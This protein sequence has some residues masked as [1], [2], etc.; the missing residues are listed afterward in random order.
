MVW[1]SQ[2]ERRMSL[3][4]SGRPLRMPVAR[5]RS[6]SPA[7]QLLDRSD[8]TRRSQH[9]DARETLQFRR[10]SV[11]SAWQERMAV[12]WREVEDTVP[13]STITEGIEVVFLDAGGVLLYPDWKRVSRILTRYGIEATSVQ[14]ADA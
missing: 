7:R 14:L 9:L 5:K 2:W 3:Q 6:G 11:S 12:P 10:G 13:A 8:T 4:P 1:A